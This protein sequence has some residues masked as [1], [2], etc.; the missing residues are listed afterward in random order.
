M[1]EMRPASPHVKTGKRKYRPNRR[2][3]LAERVQL[4]EQYQLG[5]S[6]LDLARQYGIN[7]HTVAKHLRKEGVTLRG[8]QIKLTQNLLAKAAQLYA[9]GQSLADVGAHLAVDASTV[10]KALKKAGVKMRDTH[11][12]EH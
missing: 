5:L 8:S 2:L 11:G 10:H 6:A 1:T 3:T 12:R 9:D 4:A 7:R